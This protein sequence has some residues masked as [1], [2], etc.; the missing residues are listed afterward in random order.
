MRALNL[1]AATLL[2]SG[3]L[4]IA[5]AP[6]QQVLTLAGDPW[7]P[8]VTGSLGEE[9]SGG[10]GV[11]LIREVFRRIDG[12][13]VRFPL[14]PWK[15]A[16]RD[17]ETGERDG[18]ALLLK[19]PEREAYMAFSEPLVSSRS[20]VWYRED[21]FPDGYE[22]RSYEDLLQRHIGL[23]RGYSYGT[24]MDRAIADGSVKV[25]KVASI[26]QLFLML[27]RDRVELALANDWVGFT[28]AES[29][30]EQARIVAAETPTG[31]D[32]YHIGFSRRSGASR[33]L[34]RVDE[35]IREMRAEG[36]IERM[37]NEHFQRD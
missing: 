36:V 3:L 1:I 4:T 27:A 22:W 29:L 12:V 11:A 13:E 25:T 30:T 7:P 14:Q 32:V 17:V 23:I 9:A 8:Y 24:R 18:I 34:S 10:I 6:A 21:R 33:W 19:T 16:L 2:I 15:R 5:P 28:I 37:V 31:E 20:L 35:V 26:R